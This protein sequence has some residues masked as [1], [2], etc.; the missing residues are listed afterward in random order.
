[1]QEIFCI[2]YLSCCL[3][4]EDTGLI[5]YDKLEETA[6]LFRPRLIIAGASAY[7]R[8]Y[9]Y[10]RMRK[11]L[12]IPMETLE[13]NNNELFF[14]QYYIGHQSMSCKPWPLNNEAELAVVRQDG[15]TK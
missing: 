7:S 9:D 12:S 5:D 2:N 11:V 4:Q 14:L 10:E 8:L 3:F 13:T 15:R 6:R 1:M